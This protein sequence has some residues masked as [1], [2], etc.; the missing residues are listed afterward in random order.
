MPAVG[1]QG[2]SGHESTCLNDNDSD[3]LVE[4][5]KPL[6][7]ESENLVRLHRQFIKIIHPSNR[8]SI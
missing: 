3:L 6:L 8:A 4:M 7:S 2:A 5:D 1:Q